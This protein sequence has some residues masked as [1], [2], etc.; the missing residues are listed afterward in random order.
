MHL[1]CNFCID[2]RQLVI[3]LYDL[4]FSIVDF[5][6][7][8]SNAPTTPAYGIYVSQLIRYARACCKYQDLLMEGSC[9]PINCCHKAA[10]DN[11]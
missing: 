7:L 11:S 5:P 2:N 3:R 6:F 4:N 8:S 9:S 1:D 10:C